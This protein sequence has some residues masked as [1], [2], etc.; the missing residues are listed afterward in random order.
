MKLSIATYSLG[1]CIAFCQWSC[2]TLPDKNVLHAEIEATYAECVSKENYELMNP[3]MAMQFDFKFSEEFWELYEIAVRVEGVSRS[4]EI[5]DSIIKR[6]GISV[7]LSYWISAFYVS[8]ADLRLL[9]DD[10]SLKRTVRFSRLFGEP[11]VWDKLQKSRMA[12]PNQHSD[13]GSGRAS[14]P[15]KYPEG[16]KSDRARSLLY[17][18]SILTQ[19]PPE[20]IRRIF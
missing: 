15:P 18:P 2:K 11:V 16:F 5:L 3:D 4:D 6:H 9:I 10:S 19:P 12:V 7:I 17:G 20:S 13:G 8:D 14:W 1:L